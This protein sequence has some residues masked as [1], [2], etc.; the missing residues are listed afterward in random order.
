MG[1]R[2]LFWRPL[3]HGI[4]PVGLNRLLLVG[5][6]LLCLAAA[7]EEEQPEK[8]PLE[9]PPGAVVGEIILDKNDV[10]DLDDE[11]ENNALYRLINKLHIITKDSV[12]QSQLLLEPG[13]D[14]SKR[15]ADESARLLRQRRYLFD[16][17]VEPVKVENGVVDLKV[18]TR[19]VW[20]LRPGITFSRS[21]GESN[22]GIDLEELNLLGYGQKVRIA[23]D[24]NVDRTTKSF[25]IQDPHILNS[26]V[27]GTLVLSDNSDGH[28]NRFN[29]TRPFYALDSRWATGIRGRDQDFRTAFWS[30]GEQAAEYQQ[31]R[32]LANAFGGWS[33]GLKDNWVRRYRAGIIFDD[34]VFSEVD[35]R[36]LDPLVPEDRRLIYP[37][38]GGDIT[39]GSYVE[40]ANAPMLTTAEIEFYG[41]V[42]F[43]GPVPEADPTCH[44]LADDD[45]SG[46]PPTVVFTAD[47][48]PV[49]DDGRDYCERVRAA[50]GRACWIN[51]A[52]L[53]HGY[54]R[55]RRTVARARDS[56]ERITVAIE[57][58]GQGMWPYD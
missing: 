15:L 58:L 27:Q 10:F 7:A 37:Y 57:A 48:D 52:G 50:G 2:R 44:P 24:E 47:C 26:R 30:L 1:E 6:L 16:A 14:Y 12:I 55:A 49:R 32:V 25:E 22:S 43:D 35:N 4:N 46:L 33:K 9:V 56:F 3:R 19:D 42:R 45:F 40:H 38:L 31:D 34:N 11:R 28:L 17:K 13:D 20:T 36:T 23:R 5:G 21:G 53:V 8:K 29:I 41:S 18:T 39:R 54:L 51:E